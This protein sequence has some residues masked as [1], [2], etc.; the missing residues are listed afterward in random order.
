MIKFVLIFFLRTPLGKSSK[1][2]KC[3]NRKG[4]EERERR[5]SSSPHNN[6]FGFGFGYGYGFGFFLFMLEM[7]MLMHAEESVMGTVSFV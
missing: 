4:E 2:W 3:Q 6:V 1:L 7:L 5:N